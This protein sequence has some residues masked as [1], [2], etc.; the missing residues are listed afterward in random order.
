MKVLLT[1]FVAM[2]LLFGFSSL[3]ATE[4]TEPC[5]C[6]SGTTERIDCTETKTNWQNGLPVDY[7][8]T[9]AVISGCCNMA[10]RCWNIARPPCAAGKP[11]DQCVCSIKPDPD[12]LNTEPREC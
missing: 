4:P 3:Y 7:T 2:G 6:P 12:C 11:A 8:C 10:G 5:E 9:A 1:G